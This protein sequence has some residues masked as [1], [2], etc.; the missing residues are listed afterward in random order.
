[1]GTKDTMDTK[2]GSFLKERFAFVSFETLVFFVR[3]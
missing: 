3:A 1:M 2:D